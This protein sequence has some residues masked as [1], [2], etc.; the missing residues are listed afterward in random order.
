MSL[1]SL[2][3]RRRAGD[4]LDAELWFHVE[5]QTRENLAA[6]MRPEDAR[7]AALRAFGNPALLRDQARSTW[8][9]TWL[10]IWIRD[11][12][13]ATR[14]LWRTPGFSL[15]AIAVMALGIG[16]NIALFTVV[17]GVLL[18]PLPFH[19]PDRL[20]SL[21]EHTN[22]Q[23]VY[24][25]VSGGV[26]SEWEKQNKSFSDLA[27]L[28]EDDYNLSGAGGQLPEKIL[29]ASSTWN[30]LSTLGVA[31]AL[32]RGFTSADDRRSA[33]GVA[34]L[35]WGLWMRRFGGD[36]AI[37]NQTIHLNTVPYTVIGV[38]PASFYYS[39]PQIQLWTPIYHDK[40]QQLMDELGAHN[41]RAVGR[42]KAGVSEAQAQ[43][44]LSVIT[45]RL[46]DQH[47]DNAF[48]SKAA[49]TKPLLEDMVG[50]LRKPFYVLLAA[51]GCVLLIACLNVANLLVA[52][53]AA[54]QRDV[55]IRSAL[56]GGS[57]RLLRERLMESLMLSLAGGAAGLLL[58]YGAV[59]WFVRARHDMSRVESIQIDAVVVLVTVGLIFVCAFFAGLV[60]TM[61]AYQRPILT[62]L[63]DA[64]RGSSAGQAHTRLR[65]TLLGAEVG[66]TVVLLVGAGLLLRSYQRLRSSDLGCTTENILTMRLDLFGKRYS[67]PAQLVNFY[68]ALL[69]RVRALPGLAA[70]GF[71]R[72]VPGQGYWGDQEFTVVEHPPLPQ[73]Q[74]QFAIN[75]ESDP[76]FFA[77]MGIPIVRGRTFDAN[78]SLKDANQT[79]INESFARQYF[80]GED[81]IGK[82]LRYDGKNWEICGIVSDTRYAL[83]E[84]PKPIQYYSLY[85]S[86][87][88]N[89]TLVIRGHGNVEQF[90]MPVQKIL[91]ELDPELPVSNVLT[92]DQLLSRSAVN[93]SFNTTLLTAF[94]ALSLLLAAAGLFG[95]L[96]YIVA[97]RTGEIGI[98]MAL[99]A[100]RGQVLESTLFDGL[101]P[102]IIGLVT[103][104][105]ASA[106]VVR[107]IQS[108]LYQTE[109]LDPSVFTAVGAL[110]LA[111]S[112]AACFLPAWRA[113]RLDP[114]Q[115]LRTE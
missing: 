61:G 12:R 73:G 74:M 5:Q 39:D 56:G 23:F 102:A 27:L 47:L 54:R 85:E 104:L 99:G 106:V 112:V 93:A 60:S 110:L 89:G 83:A 8:S 79:V 42:L 66:L 31:P 40:P 6:G 20:I 80:P 29:G 105:A 107:S 24:N 75:R 52:R 97:Q 77:A 100:Q 18:K 82:H 96:S 108:L 67:Q 38:L 36:R 78:R 11:V 2:F 59:E 22:E 32:G 115:A 13:I 14:T 21:Y 10:D 81:P 44:D 9:W 86:E 72:A 91:S 3:A 17:R 109:A 84:L 64:S 58:A 46:H 63:Q 87:L 55:A 43:A 101:K 98:R 19:D 71:T 35:S 28:S 103:G 69:E 4:D 88:N 62:S 50:D 65:A 111:V 53:S 26:F 25:S 16:A 114:M 7:S 37:L 1:R 68:R 51:T 49:N 30:L 41:F 90:A 45:R 33:N 70:A 57:L 113:S 48:V 94:A 34:L 92:M 95:V 15:I 76:G